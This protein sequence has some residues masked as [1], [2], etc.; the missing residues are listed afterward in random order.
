M[1]KKTYTV[2]IVVLLIFFVYI[3]IGNITIFINNQKLKKAITSINSDYIKLN[4]IV[5]FDWD[6]VYT[7]EPYTTKDEIE[8][9][10]GFKSN[11]IKETV[12]EGM[13]QLIFTK[14]KKIISSICGYSSNLGYTVNFEKI[15]NN[16]YHK[17]NYTDNAEFMTKN[18]DK[19]VNLSYIQ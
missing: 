17:I 15:N 6:S 3:I 2:V 1:K 10:L 18:E 13:V 16:V 12:N 7:F 8:S 11:A 9:I 14:D 4:E 19:I 5:P